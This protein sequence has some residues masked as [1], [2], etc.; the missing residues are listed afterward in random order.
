MAISVAEP[1]HTSKSEQLGVLEQHMGHIECGVSRHSL[2][3]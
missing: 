3:M 2:D 1:L